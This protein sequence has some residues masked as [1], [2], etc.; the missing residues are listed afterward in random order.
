MCSAPAGKFRFSAAIDGSA[1]QSRKPLDR[2][3]VPCRDFAPDVREV[4]RRANDA[5]IGELKENTDGEREHDRHPG[6]A[7]VR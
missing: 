7:I 4:V 5:R 3:V 2:L 1:I 6:C